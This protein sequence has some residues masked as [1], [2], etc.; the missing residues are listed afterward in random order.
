MPQSKAYLLF[1]KSMQEIFNFA[2]I[3]TASVP[4]LKQSLKLYKDDKI[5]RMPD[6]DYFQPSVVYVITDK[7]LK[8]LLEVGVEEEKIREL[9]KLKGITYTDNEF[10]LKVTNAIGEDHYKTHR[11]I[12][13]KQSP[14]YVASLENSMKG[15]QNSL[16]IYLYFSTFSYFEAF[17][18]DL[19]K[20]I[21]SQF[22]VLD[23]QLYV[24][25]HPID[26]SNVSHRQKVNKAY[27]PRKKDRYLK[28]S[29]ILRSAGYKTP[30]ELLFLTS[31]EFLNEK[32][33]DMKANDI[34]VFLKKAF[35]FEIPEVELKVY[36]S[37]RDN[38]NSIGHGTK[39]FVPSLS[40]VIKAKDFFKK[41]SFEIDEHVVFHFF[42]LT[43]FAEK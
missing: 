31:I 13:K 16:S 18:V 38:R 5:S 27:D 30:E 35:F 1:R 23:K 15:Y 26:K 10:K 3:V 42:R 20:E 39:S 2:V 29:K 11:H 36:H 33:E 7:T 14:D 12:L 6:V 17:V 4:T 24:K 37:L 41:L 21:L 9:T 19:A 40:D 28:F 34:P 32:V 8:Q 22:T 43:N 25:S